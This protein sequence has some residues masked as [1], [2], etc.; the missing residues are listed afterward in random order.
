[1]QDWLS[2]Y[3]DLRA[4]LE[5]KGEGEQVSIADDL[6]FEV[7]LLKSVDIDLDYILMLV[8]KMGK[9]NSED[10]EIKAKIERSLGASH[11]LRSKRDL[12]MDFVNADHGGVMTITDQWNEYI[13]GR[14][15]KEL[16]DLVAKERLKP[17]AAAKVIAR[18]ERAG[19]VPT[20][21]TEVI[22]LLASRPSRFAKPEGGASLEER[23]RSVIA[24]IQ[25]F[26]DRFK[27]LG[28]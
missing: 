25:A 5:E 15:E 16:K 21:G 24:A 22:E 27:G 10:E 9:G 14:H 2:I 4:D 6:V 7:E 23:K 26:I 28:A 19:E 17:D 8:E 11:E 3:E 1:M 13:K 18:F 20:V 12:I